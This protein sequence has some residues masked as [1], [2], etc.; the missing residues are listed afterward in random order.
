MKKEVT[1]IDI[2]NAVEIINGVVDRIGDRS[3]KVL[4]EIHEI[5]RVQC[6]DSLY[7]DTI[8]SH[9]SEELLAK[10]TGEDRYENYQTVNSYFPLEIFL[11]EKK[12]EQYLTDLKK[13]MEDSLNRERIR[14]KQRADAKKMKEYEKYIEL[15]AKFENDSEKSLQANSL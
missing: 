4:K 6:V 7:L 2:K 5:Q 9:G 1:Y 3:L 14:E 8:E 11:S 13:T 15:K 12:K 10:F